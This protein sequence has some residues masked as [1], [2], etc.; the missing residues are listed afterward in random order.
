IRERITFAMSATPYPVAGASP[1]PSPPVQ[2]LSGPK[3]HDVTLLDADLYGAPVVASGWLERTWHSHVLG[4]Q[5]PLSF[6]AS[7]A[8]QY[9]ILIVLSAEKFG[10]S[11]SDLSLEAT[12]GSVHVR[13]YPIAV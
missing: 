7:N 8:F 6:F 3:I 13:E 10:S 9:K 5:Q 12:I 11:G 4:L 1:P 2:P